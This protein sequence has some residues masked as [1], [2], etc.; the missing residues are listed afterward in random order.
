MGDPNP[1]PSQKQEESSKNQEGKQSKFKE[2]IPPPDPPYPFSPS[3]SF[4]AAAVTGGKIYADIM[5]KAMDEGTRVA[6]ENALKRKRNEERS[7][8]A[9]VVPSDNNQSKKMI[10]KSRFHPQSS[11]EPPYDPFKNSHP[12]IN[13]SPNRNESF[14]D[15]VSRSTKKNATT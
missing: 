3:S 8:T 11:P 10:E 5:K 4:G 2:D 14:S 6:R 12:L 13:I 15:R 1:K 7:G 9:L